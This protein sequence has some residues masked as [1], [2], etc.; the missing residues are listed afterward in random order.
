MV[1][2]DLTGEDLLEQRLNVAVSVRP[3]RVNVT[4][5]SY[6]KREKNETS[7]E[8]PQPRLW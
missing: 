4:A 7:D 3:M 6:A 8:K 5:P 2:L 1:D